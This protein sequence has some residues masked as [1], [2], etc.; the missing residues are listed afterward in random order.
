MSISTLTSK[1]QIT[2]PKIIRD[3]FQLQQ[4]DSVVFQQNENGNWEISVPRSI[5]PELKG[6]LKKYRKA[7]PTTQD[8]KQIIAKR[9]QRKN[10]AQG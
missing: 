8:W 7:P 9:L 3:Q 4:G 10:D 2:L 1:G 5:H 6:M